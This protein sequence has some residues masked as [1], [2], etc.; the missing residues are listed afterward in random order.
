MPMVFSDRIDA[1]RRLAEALATWRGRRPLVCA[2]PRGAV[3]MGKV[4][5]DALGGD[6]DVV[7]TQD[8][9]RLDHLLEALAEPHHQPRLRDHLAA[10][11]LLAQLEHA[12][13]AHEVRAAPRPRV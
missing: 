6:L 3:P 1:G 12:A 2:I 4:V 11:H 10:A 5:A 7:L 8:P 13:R 9:E